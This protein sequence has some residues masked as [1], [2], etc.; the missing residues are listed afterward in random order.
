MASIRNFI[1]SF[2]ISVTLF[3]VIAY[4]AI[5]FMVGAMN[6]TDEAPENKAE[7]LSK[8][9]SDATGVLNLLL[10]GTD[11]Y[12]H[13]STDDLPTNWVEESFEELTDV[14]L[15]Y[16]SQKIVFMTLVSFNSYRQQVTVTAFPVEMTVPANG[17]E[18][19]LDSAYYFADNELYGLTKDYF[20]HAISATVGMQ[21]DYSATIDIDDYVQV[22]DNLGGLTVDCPEADFEAD[23]TAGENTLTSTQLR[24]LLV[25]D[26][27]T[28]EQ[29][30]CTLVSN[31]TVEALEQIC[32]TAYYVNAFDEF[33]R[34]QPMLQNTAFDRDALA[35]WRSL[36][37]SYKFY[38]LQKLSPIGT[39]VENEEGEMVFKIDRSSTVNYFKQYM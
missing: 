21:I 2:L 11:E 27:Y 9:T 17:L 19:D 33:E 14:D 37:F 23:V 10:I 26:D 4:F 12:P 34:I 24:R 28:D 1:V 5:D 35:Q 16:Y 8:L 15:R 38:T 30:K 13:P 31:V 29:S 20:V 22:A 3:S 39:Y 25:K 36:I 6:Q 7:E 32:S 18:L